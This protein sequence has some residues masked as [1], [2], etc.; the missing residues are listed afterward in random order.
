MIP[1]NKI[2]IHDKYINSAIIGFWRMGAD[3]TTIALAVGCT[4]DRVFNTIRL[5]KDIEG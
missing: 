2:T 3:D 4:L 5:Y 1:P